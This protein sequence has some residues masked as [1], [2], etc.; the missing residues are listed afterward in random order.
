VAAASAPGSYDPIVS[1]NP[2]VAFEQIPPRY[3]FLLDNSLY[4][5][6]TFIHGPVCKGQIA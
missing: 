3:Q 2:F 6:M 4:M 5:L 1:A